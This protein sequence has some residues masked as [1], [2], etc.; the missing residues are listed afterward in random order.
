MFY[1]EK[2]AADFIPEIAGALAKVKRGALG[3]EMS[4]LCFALDTVKGSLGHFER[5]PRKP[6]IV[7]NKE[8]A[9]AYRDADAKSVEPAGYNLPLWSSKFG[10]FGYLPKGVEYPRNKDAGNP[11]ALLIQINFEEMAAMAPQSDALPA[12]FPREGILSVYTD[13][14]DDLYGCDLDS[15]GRANS[16]VGYRVLYF[17][18]D[19]VERD[20]Y[21]LIGPLL[22]E[23]KLEEAEDVVAAQLWT[24]E[25]QYDLFE[26]FS[27][28]HTLGFRSIEKPLES[29]SAQ[30]EELKRAFRRELWRSTPNKD[31]AKAFAADGEAPVFNWA[32]PG[33]W[34]GNLISTESAVVFGPAAEMVPNASAE[35]KSRFLKELA[36]QHPGLVPPV[37]EEEGEGEV[38][39]MRY[40]VKGKEN[41][42]D[43]YLCDVLLDYQGGPLCYLGGYP[44]FTQDDPRDPKG[45]PDE[46]FL[47][48]WGSNERLMFGDAGMANFFIAV[49]DLKQRKLDRMWFNW[50]CC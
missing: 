8:Q 24:R 4:Q 25:E 29:A 43:D 5:S 18:A 16:Q 47:Q 15:L 44:D 7:L 19:S 12:E 28:N 23:S 49:D 11:L 26:A 40:F 9:T 39:D 48:F 27:E 3:M 32:Q 45:S 46:V 34:Y 2:F 35:F 10:G 42:T 30:L 50:D 38:R 33:L 31:F 20:L 41:M 13:P 36:T 14:F 6:Y 37:T 1:S 21:G 22:R 17:D